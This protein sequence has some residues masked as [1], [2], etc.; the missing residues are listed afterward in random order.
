M[1]FPLL[2]SPQKDNGFLLV[3]EHFQKEKK[4]HKSLFTQFEMSADKN[5]VTTFINKVLI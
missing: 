2:Q 5:D 1:K 3:S 4:K